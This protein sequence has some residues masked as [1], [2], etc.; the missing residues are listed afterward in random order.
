MI[1]N[2]K[3]KD[4]LLIAAEKIEMGEVIIYSTDTL[5]GFG[6]DATNCKAIDKINILKGRKQPYSI[7]VDSIEMIKKYAYLP[8]E[9][10]INL[11]NLLPGPYTIL[12]K[13]KD[14]NLSP[15]VN[16]NNGILGF[17]IPDN[18]FLLNLVKYINKPIITT[19]VNAHGEKSLNSLSDIKNKFPKINSFLDSF[20]LASKGS[21][22]L[23]LSKEPFE[24]LRV[25]DGKI[26][27]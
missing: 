17:R 7:I 8:I 18:E 2:V 23:N 3:I 26:N 11:S 10:K 20:K 22:I 1:Y 16:L 12:L 15:L 5:P 6:V 9:N 13:E 14:N 21:T 25:G 27:L 4:S 19:S 24:V